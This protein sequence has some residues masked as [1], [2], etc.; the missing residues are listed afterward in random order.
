[1]ANMEF[2]RANLLNTTTMI[3]ASTGTGTFAYAFNRNND[4]SYSTVGHT[5]NTSTL[6]SI[7]FQGPTVISQLLLLNHNLRQFRA[8]YNS[9]TASVFSTDIN[10][11]TNSQSSSYFAFN[12]VTVNSVQIQMDRAMTADIERRIGELI[13]T[14]RRL[15]W[16]VNASHQNFKPSIKRARVIHTMPDGGKAVFNIANKYQAK[17]KLEFISSTFTSNLETVWNEA[18]ALV[19]VPYPTIGS[20]WNGVAPETVFASENFDFTYAENS[21]TQGYTGDFELAETPSA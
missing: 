16:E 17:V 10:T 8:F 6:I 1:M 2:L 3:R 15:R 21:K 7:E 4:L 12:S 11:T 13:V 5:T 9:T 14:E 19:F 20:D 18:Q